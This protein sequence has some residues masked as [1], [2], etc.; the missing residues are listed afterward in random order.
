MDQ[1][2]L[3]LVLFDSLSFVLLDL[4]E[5]ILVSHEVIE[6]HEELD[7]SRVNEVDLSGLVSL[8]VE[9]LVGAEI[10]WLELVNNGSVELGRSSSEEPDLSEDLTVGLVD[11]LLSEVDWQL[12]QKLL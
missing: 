6:V 5:Q 9:Q 11:D 2:G 8:L 1:A 12:T 7:L 10:N 4:S 3:I